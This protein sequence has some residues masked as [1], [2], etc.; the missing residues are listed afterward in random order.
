MTGLL[1]WLRGGSDELGFDDLVRRI[2]DR[3]AKLAHYGA[4]GQVTFPPQVT[5]R[6]TVAEGSVEVVRRFV[7]GPELDR[8]VSAALANACDCAVR[9]LPLREYLVSAADKTTITVVEG[10]AKSWELLVEGGDRAGRALRLPGDQ[11]ELRFGRGA[12]HGPDQQI[13]NDLVIADHTDYVSRRAGRLLR[14]GHNFEVE[15]LDQGDGLV[16]HR[17]DGESLRPARTARGRLIVHPG[18]VIELGDGRGRAVRL[19]VRRV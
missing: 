3:V 6:I 11:A 12:W 14:A 4:R 18:D 10:P 7:E 16:V 19:V 5:V 8:E 15:A 9:D 2:A 17:Q 1:R 13:R